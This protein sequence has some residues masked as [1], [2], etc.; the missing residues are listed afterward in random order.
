[1]SAT[2]TFAAMLSNEKFAA[3]PWGLAS[4]V[5]WCESAMLVHL[6]SLTD[7]FAS[8]V[9]PD[10]DG[11]VW[12]YRS[13]ADIAEQLSVDERTVRRMRR[14][15]VSVGAIEAKKRKPKQGAPVPRVHYFVDLETVAALCRPD[16]TSTSNRTNCPEATGQIVHTV[17]STPLLSKK[18]YEK[19]LDVANGDGLTPRHPS[20]KKSKTVEQKNKSDLFDG[21]TTENPPAPHRI[22][23][24]ARS[25]TVPTPTS[26]EDC[27]SI[28]E[29][30]RRYS[31]QSGARP[32]TP[33]QEVVAP[34]LA[35]W[36]LLWGKDPARTKWSAPRRKAWSA[37]MAEGWA[38]VDFARA[39]VGMTWDDWA[40]RKKHCDWPLVVRQMD[41]WL[42]LFDKHGPSAAPLA[43]KNSKTINGVVVPLDYR[44]TTEDDHG[45]AA[46]MVFNFEKRTWGRKR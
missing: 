13:D 11:R 17:G 4:S 27:A 38:P 8:H 37:A 29:H 21:Q 31:E 14:R 24:N 42:E 6:A 9:G 16:K 34:L 2:T 35:L 41:R 39:I 19:E 26:R 46:G 23:D 36:A 7:Y 1:M 28:V 43:R 3:I 32:K 5:G 15:L 20:Q 33:P 10:D 12:I 30:L 22:D 18:T 45:L 44:W 25:R 40:D